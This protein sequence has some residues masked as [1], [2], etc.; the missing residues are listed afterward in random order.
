MKKH[1]DFSK[2]ERGKFYHPDAVFN[3]PIYLEQNIAQ[4]IKDI[5]ES[6]NANM[7]DIVNML[8][9]KDK[10]LMESMQKVVNDQDL[11]V[12]S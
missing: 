9:M 11:I 7:S 1:Y 3:I 6:R 10:E 2:G 8:L 5:A 4:F 12:E